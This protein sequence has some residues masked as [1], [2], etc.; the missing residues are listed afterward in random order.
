MKKTEKE[1]RSNVYYLVEG[2]SL[3]SARRNIDEVMGG[4]MIDYVVASVAETTIMDVYEYGKSNDKPE[5]EQQ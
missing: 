5:Y 1:K 2:C 3:E 4:T